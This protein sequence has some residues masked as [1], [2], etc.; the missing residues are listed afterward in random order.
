MGYYSFLFWFTWRLLLA[1]LA[2]V[3]WFTAL[4]VK[5]IYFT[6]WKSYDLLWFWMHL[7]LCICFE[8]LR[9]E[10]YLLVWLNLIHKKCT[11]KRNK[12]FRIIY[13]ECY[14]R[15]FTKSERELK[16]LEIEEANDSDDD[17]ESPKDDE[18]PMPN[19]SKKPNS[20]GTTVNF[21]TRQEGEALIDG[22]PNEE[23]KG[24]WSKIFKRS[25]SQSP[26]SET[27]ET[28]KW[29]K[30]VPSALQ[31]NSSEEDAAKK[32]EKKLQLKAIR[33]RR[34]EYLKKQAKIEKRR[35]LISDAI[36][37]LLQCLRLFTTF[38][39]LVG[40]VHKTFMP[41]YL[42]SE[43]HQLNNP[44][45]VMVFTITMGLDMFLFWMMS[46]LT[47]YKNCRLCCRLGICKFWV[48]LTGLIILGVFGMY[49]P[50][51]MAMEQLALNWC[52]FEVGTPLS[53]VFY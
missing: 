2:H 38:A 40:N 6:F 14:N 28:S 42:I 34:K 27:S 51:H 35:R 9:S 5:C 7:V 19:L 47:Y 41:S 20:K 26:V 36:E 52:H 10:N 44:D 22:S 50:M 17:E 12:S 21:N 3:N 49:W 4:Y 16:K 18:Q 11:T 8:P 31:R 43:D 37:L 39:I 29:S 48:W 24:I 46:F 15:R 33:Q 13:N 1:I 45:V 30:Y 25:G 53:E 23:N 32:K